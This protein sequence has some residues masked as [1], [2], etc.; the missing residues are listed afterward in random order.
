[1]AMDEKISIIDPQDVP[2]LLLRNGEISS[3][4]L[5]TLRR[6]GSSRMSFHV[7][8]IQGGTPRTD[9]VVYPDMDEINYMVKGEGTVIFD[10]QRRKVTEGMVWYIPAGCRYG[11]EN[12]AEVTILSV[13]SPPRE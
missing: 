12:D 10:G 2:E 6:E 5:V 9:D 11:L 1:M 3:R 7:N 13:F 4:R 8:V